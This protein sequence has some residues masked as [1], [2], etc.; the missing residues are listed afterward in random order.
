[1]LNR[2]RRTPILDLP[3]PEV[4]KE[5]RSQYEELAGK[6]VN[7]ILGK[8]IN[9]K[10]FQNA[11]F[12]VRKI[13]LTKLLSTARSIALAELAKSYNVKTA[14]PKEQPVSTELMPS[15]LQR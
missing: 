9:E 2:P 1:M 10:A 6:H 7:Q 12:E 4:P 5:L 3:A 8:A 13:I 11:P 14:P 15:F